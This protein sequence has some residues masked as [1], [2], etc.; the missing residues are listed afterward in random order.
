M[1]IFFLAYD[2]V[3][4]VL[5]EW[6]KAY[7]VY[8]V[9][10]SREDAFLALHETSPTLWCDDYDVISMPPK[11]FVFPQR[12]SLFSWE[13]QEKI[14]VKDA[15]LFDEE[16]QGGALRSNKTMSVLKGERDLKSDTLLFGVRPC[17]AYGL[18]YT[19]QFFSQEYYDMNYARRAKHMHVVAINCTQ[20]AQQC[21]CN[22]LHTGPFL[23]TEAGF[24]HTGCDM[25]LTPAEEGYMVE[26]HS[27][28]G[29]WMLTLIGEYVHVLH[30]A[31]VLEQKKTILEEA[32]KNF[33]ENTDFTTLKDAL[34]AGF[35]HELW[36]RIAPSCISCT[37]CTRVCP[38]CTCFTTRE[39][40]V[41]QEGGKRVRSWD[42]CQSQSFTRN[43][44]WHNPRDTVAMVRYRIYDKF[45][46]IEDRFN[47]KG[48][49]GCGRCNSTCPANIHIVEIAKEIMQAHALQKE[50]GGALQEEVSAPMQK[51]KEKV[52]F[53]DHRRSFDTHLYVPKVVEII[54]IYDEAENI[55][56]FT[57]RYLG[58]Q[59]HG[60]PALR[61]QFFMIT[62]FGVGEIAISVPFS[63]REEEKFSFYIKK[64][65]KVTTSL[66][67]KKIGDTLG[68]RGPYG[69]PFPYESFKGRT[70][71]VIGSGVGYAPVRAPLVRAL[72]NRKDFKHIIMIAS[73]MTY[74]ELM[75]K[76]E[77]HTWSK[78]EGVHVHYALAKPTTA[79]DA[80]VGYINDLLPGLVENPGID[81]KE[82]SAIICASVRRIRAVAD[83][84]VKLGM[85]PTDIYTALETHMRCGVGKCGHC[86]VGAYYI[87]S[88]GPVFN[89][90]Q[91]QELP[92]EF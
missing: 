21:F 23:N 29:Q 58:N 76:E 18:A 12:E 5:T 66:F 40:N 32:K 6:E 27:E 10:G 68:L 35:E 42:S 41:G 3:E 8:T 1:S 13:G 74:E 79:I 78:L 4:S 47:K 55:K 19:Q 14:F 87:C 2:N 28:K 30:D 51:L 86:K 36:Q 17:D 63:D 22:A 65:G 62:D 69:V 80:H 16:W 89:Y 91:I 88:D 34:E 38:T 73:A 84:L 85:N 52:P 37:G 49:T 75:L 56:R 50:Q 39:K 24:G 7:N 45:K 33:A 64:V 54:D 48:C 60:R 92:P 31:T 71:L 82:T 59:C 43:A 77:L 72:E 9:Q 26:V 70:L 20:P 61:G 25:E 83:D 57:V 53:I 90:A 67:N 11:S 81:W 44:G 46:Y 15:L